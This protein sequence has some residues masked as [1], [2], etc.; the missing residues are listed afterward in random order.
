MPAAAQLPLPPATDPA[1]PPP[2]PAPPQIAAQ[3]AA[4]PLCSGIL[5][6]RCTQLHGP[7]LLLLGDAEGG[8]RALAANG[9]LIAAADI[10]PLPAGG[11]GGAGGAGAAG[12]SV[13]PG[14]LGVTALIDQFYAEVQALGGGRQDTSSLIRRL[15]KRGNA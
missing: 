5:R 2:H 9:T 4:N 13:A 7:S 11:A 3:L 1:S 12:R 10:A 6:V 15:P 14:S 8:L